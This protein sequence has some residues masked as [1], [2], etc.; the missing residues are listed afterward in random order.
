M[1][2]NYKIIAKALIVVFLSACNF[3]GQTH[4]IQISAS[5]R[6]LTAAA[7]TVEAQIA[8][9]PAHTP[10]PDLNTITISSSPTASTENTTSPT[11]ISSIKPCD[12]AL[13]LADIN[14]PDGTIFSPGEVFRKTWR[15]QNIG[16]C[17]WTT[18]YEL[19]FFSEEILGGPSSKQLANVAISPGEIV[20]ISV[21]LTAPIAAGTY[22]GYWKLRNAMGEI[23]T[24]TNDLAFWVEIDVLASTATPGPKIE[25]FTLTMVDEGAVQGDG[26]VFTAPNVGDTKDDFGLQAFIQFD[27]S[28]IPM[29]ALITEVIVSFSNFD[30]LG[31]PFTDLGCLRAYR[32]NYF[33]LDSGDYLSTS[34]SSMKWCNSVE[35]EVAAINEVVKSELQQSLGNPK[36]EYRLQFN[37]IESD[38]DGKDDMVRF[39]TVSLRITYQTEP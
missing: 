6:V 35:L 25:S 38:F 12:E 9:N 19:V 34:E 28:K 30:T 3:P 37:E 18:G 17:I 23:F 39:G 36:L 32:G 13:F 24:F 16:S 20:D 31:D 33:P 10:E 27:I 11:E 21:D 22:R 26:Q 15:L 29:N 14:V 2:L 1:R 8:L 7:K 4:E 5:D